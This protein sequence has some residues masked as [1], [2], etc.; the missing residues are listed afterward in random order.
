MRSFGI[1]TVIL[2]LTVVVSPI[3]GIII[4]QSL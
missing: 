4:S 2:F 3:A 1:I